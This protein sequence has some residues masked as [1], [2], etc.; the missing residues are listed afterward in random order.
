[1]KLQLLALPQ[2]RLSDVMRASLSKDPLTTV[3]PLLS[4][5]HLAALDRRLARVLKAVADCQERYSNAIYNDITDY[6]G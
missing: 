2:H 6:P 5:Q 4:E 3:A 1:M